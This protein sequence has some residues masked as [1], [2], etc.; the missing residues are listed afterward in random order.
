MIDYEELKT[1]LKSCMDESALTFSE[2]NLEE[3]AT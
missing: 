3:L 2:E 1:V